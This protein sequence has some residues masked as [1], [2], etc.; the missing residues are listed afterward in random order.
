MNL[1]KYYHTKSRILTKYIIQQQQQQQQQQSKKKKK[2]KKKKERWPTILVWERVK[3]RNK[4][5]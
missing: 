2:K 5:T 3:S 1:I 4:N